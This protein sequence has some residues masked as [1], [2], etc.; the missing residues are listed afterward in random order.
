MRGRSANIVRWE[1]AF[2]Y[3]ET[4]IMMCRMSGP[5]SIDL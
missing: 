4:D 5:A 3:H 2:Y 1:K